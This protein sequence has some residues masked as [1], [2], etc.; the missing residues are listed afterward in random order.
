V[1]LLEVNEDDVEV[2]LVDRSSI[3]EVQEMVNEAYKRQM[4]EAG[5]VNCTPQQRKEAEAAGQSLAIFAPRDVQN[6]LSWE[7]AVENRRIR[8]MDA[9][10]RDLQGQG[11]RRVRLKW[12]DVADRFGIRTAD[13]DGWRGEALTAL[14]LASS[15]PTKSNKISLGGES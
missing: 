12:T 14:R 11:P 6:Q 13:N 3:A 5:A 15:L 8:G 2:D 9:T 10:G 4:Q 7:L 1:N